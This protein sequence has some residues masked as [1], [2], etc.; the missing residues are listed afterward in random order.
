MKTIEK[1]GFLRYWSLFFIL[2]T[3]LS[4]QAS[5]TGFTTGAGTVEDPFIILT[6]E[7]LN[8]MR[9]HPDASYKLGADIDLSAWITT[10]SPETGWQPMGTSDTPFTGT[11]DGNG[12]VIEN[13]WI[14]MSTEIG[15]AH[16]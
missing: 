16:V 7:E 3:S 12:H 5:D 8:N 1:N 15:R 13:V 6:A 14:N 11:F 9:N 10:N 2:C 4:L